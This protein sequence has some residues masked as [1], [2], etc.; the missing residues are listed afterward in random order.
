MA[1]YWHVERT[2]NQRFPFRITICDDDGIRLAVRAQD[3]WPGPQGNVFCLREPR[4]S[5]ADEPLTPVERVPIV[6]VQRMGKRVSVV[7]DRKTRKRCDFLFLKRAYKNR[8]GEYEQIYF[9]TQVGLRAHKTRNRLQIRG[10]DGLSVA[11][12]T[13]ERYPW[14]FPDAEVRREPLAAGDYALYVSERLV[15]VVERKSHENLLGDLGAIQVFHQQLADLASYPRA[16]VVVEA[17]YADFLDAKRLQGRVS[18]RRLARALAELAALHPTVPLVYAGNR[19]LANQWVQAYFSAV[20]GSL[21]DLPSEHAA[22]PSPRYAGEHERIDDAVRRGIVETLPDGFR[23]RDLR[24][25]FPD[26][27]DSRLRR[28]LSRL[29]AQG[30]IVTEGRASGTRYRVIPAGESG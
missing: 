8:P 18:P 15:A 6:S 24:S 27:P 9:R 1:L 3:K 26:V 22:D 20:A 19:K 4:G 10:G 28:V 13:Q 14:R 16:A 5:A 12:D 7:L 11:V 2:M 17:Q 29:R 23:F 25:H 21:A 30:R